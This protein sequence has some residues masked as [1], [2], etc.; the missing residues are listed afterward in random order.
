M[1]D[2]AFSRARWCG[3]ASEESRAILT[4]GARTGGANHVVRVL[5]FA[6]AA[7]AC[8][9]VRLLLV[10]ALLTG[11]VAPRLCVGERRRHRRVRAREAR[12]RTAVRRVMREGTRRRDAG[13]VL[14]LLALGQAA[15]VLVIGLIGVL[16]PAEASGSVFLAA[17][18]LYVAIGVLVAV[19]A[20]VRQAFLDRR[21]RRRSA[22]RCSHSTRSSPMV[23]PRRAAF[24]S[25]R[26]RA[27]SFPSGRRVARRRHHDARRGTA[28]RARERA[29]RLRRRSALWSSGARA[30][31]E[32]TRPFGQRFSRPSRLPFRHP[33]GDA[34]THHT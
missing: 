4:A 6:S 19:Q 24:G 32:P 17:A 25:V 2:W 28:S 5:F 23:V 30:G 7:R 1:R 22:P 29:T 34:R 8:S 15:L 18:G 26:C 11:P 20:P 9:S 33:A 27:R 13:D 16:V 31:I 3:T 21:S 10:A 14:A 12:Q